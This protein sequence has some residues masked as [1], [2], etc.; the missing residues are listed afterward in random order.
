MAIGID[1][2]IQYLKGV[3]PKLGAQLRKKG[4]ETVGNLLDC[5]PRSYEDRRAGRNIASLVPDEIVSLE[6][7][8]VGVRSYALGRTRKKIYDVALRDSSGVVHCKFFRVPYKGY[9]DR[10]QANMEVKVT[11]KVTHYR[12][13]IEFHHPDIQELIPEDENEDQLVPIYSE[14]EGL[15]SSRWRKLVQAAALH[16]QEK[17]FHG[18]AEIFPK[19]LM[20]DYKLPTRREAL[21]A[22]HH[23][24][25]GS[26]PEFLEKQ[27]PFHR[28]IIFEEFFWLELYLASRQQGLRK[29]KALPLIS[30]Q[31]LVPRLVEALPF[32][33]TNAQKRCFSEIREDIKKSYPMNR[34]VQG[35]VG[36][37]KTMVAL[38]SS[39]IAIENQQ[40]VALM[41]PTEI[42]AQQHFLGA[43]KLLEP[44]GLR[45]SLLSGQMKAAEKR[46]SLEALASGEIDIVVG[47]HA[48]IQNGVEFKSLGLVIVD[49]QHR[50]GV[51][52]RARLKRK[53]QSPHFLLMT[54]TPIP[55]SLA[56]TVYGD[57]EVSVIDELP[58]GRQP[59]V[60]RATYMSKRDK[61][62]QFVEDQLVKGRQA[63]IVFPLVEESEK[64]DLANATDE[65]EKLKNHWPHRRLALLHGKMKP[66]EKE[67]VMAAF[68]EGE[69]DVLVSTTVIEVGVDV[70]NANLI[71]INNSE[72]FGLSQLHQLRGRV[73]RGAHKSYCIL[74][75][76]YAVSQDSKNRIEIM[77]KTIDG[78]KVSEADLEIRGPGEFMGSRQSGLPGFRM[79]N[80]VRDR[81]I[82]QEARQAAFNLIRKDPLL[83]CFEHQSLK[84]KFSELEITS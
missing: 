21:V 7:I 77:E 64:M 31:S 41:V 35:D 58:K 49:E 47:T 24:P 56:M 79:A 71:W 65:F 26:G 8:V 48:L 11:G 1:T 37:G 59:I 38:L 72:R 17:D 13:N 57:L 53:G 70:P 74:M 46:Q 12:G 23:P 83:K 84:R 52:Q 33:L 78:F 19:W 43:R 40:Q 82:L 29:E 32:E 60:T 6:T 22:L 68:R 50:F 54:A 44:L 66:D 73:G 55:R 42:L 2:P 27:T 75:M 28:R 80:L 14:T 3:G 5:Y 67:S 63:Y 69:F 25:S 45:V 61:V 34:M 62:L 39:L 16:A 4:V 51:E 10:F 18:L 36:S 15:T 20:E 30:N 9:F 81:E 76:G